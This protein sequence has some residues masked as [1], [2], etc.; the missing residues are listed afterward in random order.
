MYSDISLCEEVY[1]QTHAQP[2]YGTSVD[3]SIGLT[4]LKDKPVILRICNRYS[5]LSSIDPQKDA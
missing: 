2:Q 3:I 1:G 5:R 4:E